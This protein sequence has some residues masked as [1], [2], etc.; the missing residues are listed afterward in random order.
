MNK[1]V[2]YNI[3]NSR[4]LLLMGLMA[5]HSNKLLLI[6]AYAFFAIVLTYIQLASEEWHALEKRVLRGIFGDV[7]VNFHIRASGLF[8]SD[9]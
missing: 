2:I 1:H 7:V 8:A 9:G 6:N 3:N 5:T 4:N